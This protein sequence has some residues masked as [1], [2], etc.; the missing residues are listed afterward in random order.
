MPTAECSLPLPVQSIPALRYDLAATLD[1]GQ[2]FRWKQSDDSWEGLVGNRWVRLR[3]RA[4]DILFE[5][6]QPEA[7]PLWLTDYLQTGVDLDKILN[8]FPDDP[9]LRQAR[10]ACDGLRLLKQDG[11]ECL[12]SFILSSTK[13]IVQIKQV[14]A[15]LCERF[16]ER[17]E[18]LNG[19]AP[20][21]SFPSAE[22]IAS[23]GEPELR[24]C[25]MGYRAPYLLNSA[26]QI[27]D[28]VVLF[29]DLDHTRAALP[30]ARAGIMQLPGVGRKVADCV[31]LFTGL[32][33]QA[34]PVDVWVMKA[35]R[36]LYFPDTH[37]SLKELQS[38]SENHFGPFA[39][40]A[41]QYLFHYMRVH[42]QLHND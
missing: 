42:R 13:Q 6:P 9:P 7:D 32:Q 11:R 27:C 24:S 22:C 41:Q 31:L 20:A 3:Q 23:L 29:E 19:H 2:S 5:T 18:T 1:S 16:G 28:G 33:P 26:R 10:Q 4:T 37:K 35:L 12:A 40:Y 17:V 8:S 15:R 38:F 21:W 39:G 36:E 34:F 14:V 25:G 30:E